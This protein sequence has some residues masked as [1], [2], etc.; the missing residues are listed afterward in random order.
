MRQRFLNLWLPLLILCLVSGVWTHAEEY[1]AIVK[2]ID[3]VGNHKIESAAIRSRI[4]IQVGDKLDRERV[5]ED[6]RSLYGMGYFD[7]ISADAEPTEGGARLVF[8]VKE[9]PIISKIKY[10]GLE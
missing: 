3:I 8:K 5:S 7:A 4:R 2:V 9:K 10:E 6:I 1:G